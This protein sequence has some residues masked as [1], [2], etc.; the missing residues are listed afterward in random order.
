MS[1][2]SSLCHVVMQSLYT[3][4]GDKMGLAACGEEEGQ[5]KILLL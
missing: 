2:S 5:G 3:H 1:S 4:P